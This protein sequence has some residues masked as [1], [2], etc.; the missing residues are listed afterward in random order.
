MELSVLALL[1]ILL[2]GVATLVYAFAVAPSTT[3]VHERL[4]N[5]FT[6]MG[7]IVAYMVQP[8]MVQRVAELLACV[9][10]GQDQFFLHG[11]LTVQCGSA[12]HRTLL[13]C[14]GLP[15]LVV[16][17]LSEFLFSCNC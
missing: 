5:S 7:V 14:L 12:E 3:S 8:T 11:D 4:R 17:V 10:L 15:I 13:L 2:V 1:P 9:E 6:C 16:Y